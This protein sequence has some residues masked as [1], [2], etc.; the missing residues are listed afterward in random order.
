MKPVVREDFKLLQ[1]QH[2]YKADAEYG[3]RIAKG[4]GLTSH[5]ELKE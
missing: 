1:I 2:F 3:E 4:L 5:L